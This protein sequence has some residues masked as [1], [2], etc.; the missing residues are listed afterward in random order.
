MCIMWLYTDLSRP[1]LRHAMANVIAVVFA[2]P[3][4]SNHLWYHVFEPYK[5]R[6]TYPPGYM[7]NESYLV[8]A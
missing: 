3:E 6:N 8:L 2:L 5:L 1:A 7:V 4:K